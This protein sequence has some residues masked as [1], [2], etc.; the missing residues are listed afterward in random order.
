MEVELVSMAGQPNITS[1][2]IR[3]AYRNRCILNTP[4]EPSC[5]AARWCQ[6]VQVMS[7][8]SAGRVCIQVTLG[9]HQQERMLSWYNSNAECC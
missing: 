7:N 6:I 3:L 9:V 5:L 4:K 2:H 1:T 8:I